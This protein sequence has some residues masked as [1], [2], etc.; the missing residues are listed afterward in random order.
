MKIA[1]FVDTNGN[2]LS[3]DSSGIVVIYENQN[4][5]WQS[6]YKVPLYIN[7]GMSLADVRESIYMI[8]P[9]LVG[10]KAFVAK[11]RMGIFNA[12]FEEEL[13][14]RLFAIQGSPVPFLN[15]I[16]KTLNTE[17]IEAIKRIE[18]SRQKKDSFDPISVGDSLKGCYQINLV[19]VQA[20]DASL[21]SKEILLPFLQNTSFRELEIICMHIPKWFDKEL[22]V[23]GLCVSTEER[24]DEYCHAFVRPING[25]IQK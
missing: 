19:K 16:R 2:T 6:I 21:N 3:F 1:I 11:R 10:C 13:H 8:A 14:I 7:E 12:I 20:K 5:D 25:S 17:I 22:Y 18:L 9:E 24:K 15:D 23:L 4:S